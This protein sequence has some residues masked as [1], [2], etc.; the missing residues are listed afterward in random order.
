[1]PNQALDASYVITKM[2]ETGN[3]F[4]AH[5]DPTRMAAVG[6]SAGGS[7]TNALFTK[8]R[9]PRL[10]AGIAISGRP[11]GT[12]TGSPVQMLFI[13]GDKDPVVAYDQGRT[14]Y[15]ADHWPKAFLTLIGTQH[16]A[17]LAEPDRGHV[18]VM[19]TMLDF[20]RWTLDDNTTAKNRLVDDGTLTGVCRFE[21]V[22]IYGSSN[23][24][25]GP[26]AA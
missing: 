16:G 22:G 14:A 13:H 25:P 23:A 12:Y 6:H 20:L 26:S 4:A 7:T 3:P 9:D 11:Q 19:T 1:V 8:H 2:L 5:I 15:N 21:S 24:S 17:G 18:Q 10:K